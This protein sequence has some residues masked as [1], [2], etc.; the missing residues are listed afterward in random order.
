[1]KKFV[2][3]T[4]GWMQIRP[5]NIKLPKPLPTIIQTFTPCTV[6]EWLDSCTKP[7]V[8]TNVTEH[9]LYTLYK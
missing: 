7:L 5:E 8:P 2:Q 6:V 1:M 3:M 4:D 9:Y